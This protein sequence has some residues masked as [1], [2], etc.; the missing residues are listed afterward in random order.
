MRKGQGNNYCLRKFVDGFIWFD[1]CQL[2]NEFKVFNVVGNQD[3][4]SF[5]GG[6]GN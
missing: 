3:E 5:Y 6:G 4:I 2:G 1:N